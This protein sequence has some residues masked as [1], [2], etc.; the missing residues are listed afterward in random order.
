MLS[1]AEAR[2]NILSA[3]TPLA[4]RAVPLAGALDDVL[5]DDVVATLNLPA[6][7]N[8][9]VDG[10]AVRSSDVAGAGENNPIHLRVLAEQPAG[11]APTHSLEPQS[12]VRIF[13]GAPLPSGA[14]AVVM[15][16]ETRPHH[17]GY[18]AIVESVD[19]GENIRRAGEDVSAGGTVLRDRKS[20]RLNS[21]H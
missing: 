16:E 5:A 1:V 8:S 11:S 7:D 21:S 20:T 10:F 18:V 14:D 12:C 2:Q 9:A 15:Q 13:T 17:E 19:L 3:I 6:W 4:A